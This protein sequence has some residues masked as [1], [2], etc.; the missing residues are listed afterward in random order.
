MM[1]TGDQWRKKLRV[2]GVLRIKGV[3]E[4]NKGCT[5][6]SFPLFIGQEKL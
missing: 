6:M 4:V 2:R 1:V 5:A 3:A